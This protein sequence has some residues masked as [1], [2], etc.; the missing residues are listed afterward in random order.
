MNHKIMLLYIYTVR[1]KKQE[2]SN[3]DVMYKKETKEVRETPKLYIAVDD[4]RFPHTFSSSIKKTDVGR[5]FE[6]DLFLTARGVYPLYTVILT[7]DD[8]EK[9]V[10][11]LNSYVNNKLEDLMEQVKLQKQILADHMEAEAKA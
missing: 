3:F 9:A 10:G 4:A 1:Y 2:S 8:E 6:D 11:L 7:E 5:V